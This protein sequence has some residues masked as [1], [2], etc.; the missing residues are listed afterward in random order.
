MRKKSIWP[1]LILVFFLFFWGREGI[2]AVQSSSDVTLKLHL[3]NLMKNRYYL[4]KDKLRYNGR[5]LLDLPY[6]EV[7]TS[8]KKKVK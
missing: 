3:L 6:L 4:R 7:D 5:A 1:T 8:N 2:A